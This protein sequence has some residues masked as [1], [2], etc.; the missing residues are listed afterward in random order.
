[1]SSVTVVKSS[2]AARVILGL[3]MTSTSL[4]ILWFT[5][6]RF[7][8]DLFQAE[9]SIANLAAAI[10]GLLSGVWGIFFF[11]W[12]FIFAEQFIR[13]EF[14]WKNKTISISRKRIGRPPTTKVLKASDIQGISWGCQSVFINFTGKEFVSLTGSE[15]SRGTKLKQFA[16]DVANGYDFPV[17]EVQYDGNQGN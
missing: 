5:V 13:A 7:I 12:L 6:T 8:P 16:L 4:V 3:V 1:M 2:V 11:P 17:S 15:L 14:D 9:F 10:I